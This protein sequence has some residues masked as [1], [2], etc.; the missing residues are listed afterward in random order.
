MDG[1]AP[2]TFTRMRVIHRAVVALALVTLLALAGSAAAQT[3][4]PA[5]QPLTAD[6]ISLAFEGIWEGGCSSFSD[7]TT[8]NYSENG[9][10]GI[11]SL[12]VRTPAQGT[13]ASAQ[14]LENWR[15]SIESLASGSS[16]LTLQEVPDV[17]DAAIALVNPDGVIGGFEFYLG[18][19]TGS[20]VAK[21]DRNVTVADLAALSQ[22]AL[23]RIAALTGGIPISTAAPVP[24]IAGV[25][26]PD[27]DGLTLED[28]ER[29]ANDLGLI[30]AI[31][32]DET[33]TDTPGTVITQRPAAGSPGKVG[34]EIAIIV[35]A[36]PGTPPPAPS[37]RPVAS[38]APAAPTAAPSSPGPVPT[39]VP[40]PLPSPSAPLAGPVQAPGPSDIS[41]DPVVVATSVVAAA[42]I[43]L[44]IPFPSA[45][46]NSTLEQHYAEIRGWLRFRRRRSTADD[47]GPTT[48]DPEPTTADP[49]PTT[50]DPEPTT[51]D[52]EPTTADPGPGG[53]S[54][55]A[56]PAAVAP[57]APAPVA[58]AVEPP[59]VAVAPPDA[60]PAAVAPAAPAGLG[61]VIDR[62]W[63][64]PA[65]ALAFFALAALLYGF[66]DPSFGFSLDSVL[67]YVGILA[68]LG[69]GSL[70]S[71]TALRRAR[72][73]LNGER[74]A[75]RVL[76]AT[77]L[78]ALVCVIVTR[79]LDFQPGYLYGVLAG[80]VFVTVIGE[81]VTGREHAITSSVVAGVGLLAFLVLGVVRALEGSAGPSG[82]WVPVDVALS[83][84][85]IGGFEG[86]L[87]GMLPLTGL[88]GAAVKR[89]SSRVWALL[90]FLG[91]LGFL[92]IIVN[93]SA[94]YLVDSS[95]TPLVKAL[96]L[97]IG[98]GL[99]S[100]SLW[101]WFRYRPMDRL[102]DRRAGGG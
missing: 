29:V 99:V 25:Q 28:A 3:S 56:G 42:G 83:A 96:V 82:L 80:L 26:I 37:A 31:R 72:E 73:H 52:P 88:P 4:P 11:V 70:A 21:L 74:G 78:V 17:G 89:W 101:A 59:D 36:V 18:G 92:H 58:V 71:T 43:V 90:L 66:L 51:A 23:P 95:S 40:L 5:G 9:T 94:G 76:P 38:E 81:G 77:L 86:L 13:G 64:T 8:C 69:I 2:A 12:V 33:S 10:P 22:V 57:A 6:D 54:A 41:L 67:L 34:D 97:L 98:F 61:Q 84:L 87:F 48:A 14:S 44:L 27:L 102:R 79:I 16:N 100:V 93:P 32:F 45:L 65:G 75:F 62:F 91:T 63:A 53:A 50:A 68:A 85:V 35:A 20:L 24:S 39:S 1:P 49:E 15:N 47:G 46:F 30:V 60:G 19:A 55:D 7:T